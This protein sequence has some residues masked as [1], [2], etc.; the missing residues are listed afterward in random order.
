MI[1]GSL[2][3]H[4]FRIRQ[5]D[6]HRQLPRLPLDPMTNAGYVPRKQFLVFSV[7]TVDMESYDRQ[8]GTDDLSHAAHVF[9]LGV[10]RI[11]E[12]RH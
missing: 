10:F 11:L 6:D 3:L 4:L 7:W 12:L 2:L 8:V 1:V 5:K 9:P